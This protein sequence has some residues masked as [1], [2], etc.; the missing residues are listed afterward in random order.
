MA[1]NDVYNHELFMLLIQL[2]SKL[3]MIHSQDVESSKFCLVGQHEVF[4]SWLDNRKL[5]E[6]IPYGPDPQN[7]G[8][9]VARLTP[10]ALRAPTKFS[11]AKLFGR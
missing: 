4:M 7:R 5:A 10:V 1:F 2:Y 3:Y 6:G 9:G 8:V 11:A